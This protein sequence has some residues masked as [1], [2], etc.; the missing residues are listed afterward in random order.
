MLKYVMSTIYKFSRPFVC[1][2]VP[3][4]ARVRSEVVDVKTEVTGALDLVKGAVEFRLTNVQKEIKGNKEELAKD[5]QAL[6]TRWVALATL[7][8]M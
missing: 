7:L 8:C 2:N 4:Q 3:V 6:N 5:V 1:M